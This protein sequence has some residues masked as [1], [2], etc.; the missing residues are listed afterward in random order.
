MTVP[1]LYVMGFFFD[2]VAGGTHRR[3]GRGRPLQ[4]QVHDTI[5]SW[6]TSLRVVGGFFSSCDHG[7]AYYWLP[8]IKEAAVHG[9]GRWRSGSSF[10]GLQPHLPRHAL[11]GLLACPAHLHLLA[12][13][14]W[15]LPNRSRRSGLLMTMLRAFA[16]DILL[17]LRYGRPFRRDP[18]VPHAGLAI[19]T[20]S[21]EYPSQPAQGRDRDPCMTI[22]PAAISPRRRQS[23][24]PEGR[25]D[26]EPGRGHGH[27]Q[28]DQVIILPGPSFIPLWT[29]L[30]LA[31]FFVASSSASTGWP[32][33]ARHP[34]RSSHLLALD[35]R[36][37]HIPCRGDRYGETA[38]EHAGVPR[39]RLVGK[40][41]TLSRRVFFA[42]LGLR[43]PL[44]W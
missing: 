42:S 41:F 32:S 43:P 31:L 33:S 28:P 11:D 22:R 38:L 17:Q 16:V 20:P 37:T 3:H 39:R 40:V 5:S 7:A 9:R 30:G 4:L 15:D 26:G 8:L 10:I 44:L 23:R 21:H 18:W 36:L 34:P 14:G 35:N 24:L 6:R 29:A 25:A 1:M 27:R 12:G 19:A 2:F 13:I